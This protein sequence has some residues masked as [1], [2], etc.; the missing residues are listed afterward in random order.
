MLIYLYL[1]KDRIR[2]WIGWALIDFRILTVNIQRYF[3]VQA[4][5]RAL[6]DYSC[7]SRVYIEGTNRAIAIMETMASDLSSFFEQEVT[8]APDEVLFMQR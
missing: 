6:Q 8:V 7:I 1:P 2:D 3:L 5:S 4:W